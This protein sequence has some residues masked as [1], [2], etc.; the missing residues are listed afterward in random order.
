MNNFSNL[1]TRSDPENAEAL[2]ADTYVGADILKDEIIS[3]KP[4]IE[5]FYNN[6]K[7]IESPGTVEAGDI[8]MVGDHFYIGLSERTNQSGADQ[9]IAILQKMEWLDRL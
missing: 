3:I 2:H 7:T 5:L 6:I 8:M 9:I 4:V 1:L